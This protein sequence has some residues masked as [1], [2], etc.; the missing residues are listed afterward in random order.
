M[1]IL[2]PEFFNQLIVYNTLLL[3]IFKI[4]LHQ[5]KQIGFLMKSM[6]NVCNEHEL[7]RIM[8]SKCV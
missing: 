4:L 8:N 2:Q 1:Y 6:I 7:V 5:I 3:P